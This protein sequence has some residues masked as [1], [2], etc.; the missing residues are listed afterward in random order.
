MNQKFP[1]IQKLLYE[2]P[3][4]DDLFFGV[5]K[6][7]SSIFYN[8]N[9]SK[10]TSTI[11]K[12]Y[13]KVANQLEPKEA[14]ESEREMFVNMRKI[15]SDISAHLNV[16]SFTPSS[17]KEASAVLG[18]AM[19]LSK[20]ASHAA[21]YV[22]KEASTKFRTALS[23]T[24]LSQANAVSKKAMA[25]KL[26]SLSISPEVS[27]F[28]LKHGADVVKNIK[29]TTGPTKI[30]ISSTVSSIISTAGKHPEAER[31]AFIIAAFYILMNFSVNMHDGFIRLQKRFL[32]M[33]LPE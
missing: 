26:L 2:G 32:K 21:A 20:Q 14:N 19:A 1:V 9:W 11:S 23:S 7:A 30:N 28:I 31:R 6:I 4:E 18:H 15:L 3:E 5:S 24:D 17:K 29:Y 16:A 10:D 25:G 22:I 13:D 12:E 33:T 27:Q 8:W